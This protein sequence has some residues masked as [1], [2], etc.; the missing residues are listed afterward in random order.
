MDSLTCQRK[1]NDS[2]PKGV[3]MNAQE[4]QEKLEK[5]FFRFRWKVTDRCDMFVIEAWFDAPDGQIKATLDMP[6]EAADQMW[7]DGW[8]SN[9]VADC[10][11][12]AMVDVERH[13][14][15]RVTARMMLTIAPYLRAIKRRWPK[16]DIGNVEI[17]KVPSSRVDIWIGGN[18]AKSVNLVHLLGDTRSMMVFYSDEKKTLF[19]K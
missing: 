14:E 5:R 19:V 8:I 17:I 3:L 13:G 10:I 7:A 9:R 4:L 6:S 15:D 11:A 2:N 1:I 18:L 12:W 16:F